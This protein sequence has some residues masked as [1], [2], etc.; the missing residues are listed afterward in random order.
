MTKS[1]ESA[2]RILRGRGLYKDAGDVR[3]AYHRQKGFKIS[4][5]ILYGSFR[6]QF[7]RSLLHVSSIEAL[8][9]I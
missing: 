7:I 8:H 3:F 9:L 5:P 6:Y 4:I 2:F 1:R